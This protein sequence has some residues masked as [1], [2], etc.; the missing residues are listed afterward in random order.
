MRSLLALRRRPR[1]LGLTEP[2]NEHHETTGRFRKQSTQTGTVDQHVS[3]VPAN[4][5]VHGERAALGRQTVTPQPVDRAQRRVADLAGLQR[6]S[7]RR[8]G[9][10]AGRRSDSRRPAVHLTH[11]AI[12]RPSDAVMSQPHH[13]ATRPNGAERPL[14]DRQ[15]DVADQPNTPSQHGPSD[16]SRRSNL[17]GAHRSSPDVPSPRCHPRASRTPKYSTNRQHAADSQ[18]ELVPPVLLRTVR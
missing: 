1:L 12:H 3:A 10:R 7:V 4:R 17:T 16:L 6:G 18:H 13:P 2:V 15:V 11:R 5:H 9:Q 8:D 14:G